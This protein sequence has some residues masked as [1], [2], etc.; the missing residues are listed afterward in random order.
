MS[1]VPPIRASVGAI[2]CPLWALWLAR[3]L[4]RGR[5][6]RG[7]RVENFFPFRMWRAYLDTVEFINVLRAE[8][9]KYPTETKS[10]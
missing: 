2:E 7:R 8:D 9:L 1:A 3:G 6:P 10:G 4:L 5:W